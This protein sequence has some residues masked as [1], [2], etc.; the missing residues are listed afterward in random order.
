MVCYN[1]EWLNGI[2]YKYRWIFLQAKSTTCISSS[3][4]EYVWTLYQL[5]I[6]WHIALHIVFILVLLH[7]TSIPIRPGDSRLSTCTL[8]LHALLSDQSIQYQC[9][10]IYLGCGRWVPID[11]VGRTNLGACGQARSRSPHWKRW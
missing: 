4:W 3:I 5:L 6:D 7:S 11:G 10:L 2:P 8:V 9:T 1:G